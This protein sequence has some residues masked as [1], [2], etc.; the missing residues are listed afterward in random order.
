MLNGK[1]EGER[2]DHERRKAAKSRELASDRSERLF[3]IGE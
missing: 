2:A 1:S 3:F